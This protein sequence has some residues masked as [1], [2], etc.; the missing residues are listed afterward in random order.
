MR[1]LIFPQ[2]F[3][4]KSAHYAQQNMVFN[5]HWLILVCALACALAVAS[6]IGILE[7]Y[8]NELSYPTKA[9][10]DVSK[11]QDSWAPLPGIWIQ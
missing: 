7:S 9:E 2:K 10:L 1:I 6:N 8:S 5:I 4:Q 3:G 11:R